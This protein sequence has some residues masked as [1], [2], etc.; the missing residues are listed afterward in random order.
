MPAATESGS[1]AASWPETPLHTSA[2]VPSLHAPCS[3][4]SVCRFPNLC[5]RFHRTGEF[6]SA[7]LCSPGS[8]SAFPLWAASLRP[9]SMH[10]WV[11][12]AHSCHCLVLDTLCLALYGA[13][14]VFIKPSVLWAG[15]SLLAQRGCRRSRTS[16][17]VR[18]TSLHPPPLCRSSSLVLLYVP[19]SSQ[20]SLI[21]RFS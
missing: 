12:R 18:G 9:P 11:T 13:T 16:S 2:P 7:L 21:S 20:P 8:S 4:G 19:P 17:P 14:T 5:F 15:R 6:Y 10:L 3:L 1:R